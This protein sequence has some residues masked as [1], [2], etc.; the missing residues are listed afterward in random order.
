MIQ[1]FNGGSP[2]KVRKRAKVGDDAT[3]GESFLNEQLLSITQVDILW[4]ADIANCLTGKTIP[5]GLT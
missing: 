4:Y 5:E 2:F 1:E 3:N